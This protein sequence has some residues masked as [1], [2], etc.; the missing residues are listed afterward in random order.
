VGRDDDADPRGHPEPPRRRA[1]A[2]RART[3]R[4]RAHIA[5][6]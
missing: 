1:R 6:V 2:V 4:T 5:S 3:S